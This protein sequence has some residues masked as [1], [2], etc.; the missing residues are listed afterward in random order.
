VM[1][2]TIAYAVDGKQYVMIFTGG[3]QSVTAGPISVVGPKVMASP[4]QGHNAIYVFA[5]P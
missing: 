1:N 4:V 5:L 3:G 2:S